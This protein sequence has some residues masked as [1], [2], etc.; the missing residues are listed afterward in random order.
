MTQVQIC[1][2]FR[3]VLV[4]P[5]ETSMQ[6]FM[7]GASIITCANAY[8]YEMQRCILIRT[9][10]KTDDKSISSTRKRKKAKASSANLTLFLLRFESLLSPVFGLVDGPHTPPTSD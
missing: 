7:C 8:D 4:P 6:N 2:Y 10:S 9:K 1:S 5:K 3:N